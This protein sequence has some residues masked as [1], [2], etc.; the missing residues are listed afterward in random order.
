M[1]IKLCD[2]V[3]FDLSSEQ[4]SAS[5]VVSPYCVLAISR[6]GMHWLVRFDRDTEDTIQQ[7][8]RKSI[9]NVQI[10]EIVWQGLQRYVHEFIYV[11]RILHTF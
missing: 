1:L 5:G 8:D 3:E 7:T 9:I 10:D 2:S 11:S 4:C 6:L